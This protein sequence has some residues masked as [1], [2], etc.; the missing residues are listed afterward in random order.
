MIIRSSLLRAQN[1]NNGIRPISRVVNVILL[2]IGPQQQ[3]VY[4][5]VNVNATT[6]V[7]PR[8][9]WLWHYAYDYETMTLWGMSTMRV[10]PK[11][12]RMRNYQEPCRVSINSSYASRDSDKRA[13]D[14]ETR[15][16][17]YSGFRIPDFGFRI[18][19]FRFRIRN[20]GF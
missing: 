18:L 7:G 10:K 5:H 20:S 3:N 17:R 12:K 2:D 6:T 15:G 19:D 8:R 14:N 9:L 1:N 16:I 4:P 11:R 13:P